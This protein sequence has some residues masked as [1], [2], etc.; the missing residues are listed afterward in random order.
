MYAVDL[1]PLFVSLFFLAIVVL[2]FSV[3][4]YK[5]VKMTAVIIPLT[6][7]ATVISYMTVDKILGYPIKA[8]MQDD[9]LYLSHIESQDSEKIFVWIIEPGS[10]KPRSISILNTDNNRKAMSDAKAKT[11]KGVKQRIK[12]KS[13]DKIKSNGKE[14]GN[15]GMTNGGEYEIYDFAIRGGSLKNYNPSAG[16]PEGQGEFDT[17]PSPTPIPQV[18]PNQENPGAV[19][20]EDLPQLEAPENPTPVDIP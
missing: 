13:S 12:L 15:S 3:Q 16:L 2:W 1:I 14:Q 11:E 9:S 6:L 17:L 8:E 7:L 5:N 10:T 19:A 18:D 4:N 20:Y